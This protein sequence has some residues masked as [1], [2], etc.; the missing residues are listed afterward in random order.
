MMEQEF[1]ARQPGAMAY[2]ISHFDML[3]LQD[4]IRFLEGRF[5]NSFL[6]TITESLRLVFPK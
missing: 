6:V 4:R 1:E 5:L 3:F 2:I